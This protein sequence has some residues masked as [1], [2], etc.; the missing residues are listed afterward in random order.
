MHISSVHTI[1]ATRPL[2]LF[3]KILLG[4]CQCQPWFP[5]IDMECYWEDRNRTSTLTRHTGGWQCSLQ[6]V[7]HLDCRGLTGDISRVT[8]VVNMVRM[9][10][11][12]LWL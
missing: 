11:V 3:T 4:R 5:S 7:A 1:S 6:E 12:A 2:K 10:A 8:C 9:D